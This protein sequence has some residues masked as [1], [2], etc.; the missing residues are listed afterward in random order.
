M[1]A[2]APQKH[3]AGKKDKRRQQMALKA[4]KRKRRN[5]Y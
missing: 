2:M 4:D 3:Y 5:G 1:A